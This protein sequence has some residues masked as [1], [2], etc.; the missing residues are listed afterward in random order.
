MKGAHWG[1][2]QEKKVAYTS[3]I[4][5]HPV[6][7][8]IF[9]PSRT[10]SI[11]RMCLMV[12]GRTGR[13]QLCDCKL[14]HCKSRFSSCFH[15]FLFIPVSLFFSYSYILPVHFFIPLTATFVSFQLLL[16]PHFSQAFIRPFPL[17]HSSISLLLPY[18]LPSSSSFPHFFLHFSLTC[19]SPFLSPERPFLPSCIF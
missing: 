3:V 19:S 16:S 6:P 14:K 5:S 7:Q 12:A 4:N 9:Q 2:R 13:V 18:S 15:Y 17:L 8:D 11:V 10:S 1:F